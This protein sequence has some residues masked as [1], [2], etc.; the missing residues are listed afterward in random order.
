MPSVSIVLPTRDRPERLR[1]ALE[2]VARQ[3]HPELELIL[4]RDGGAPIAADAEEAIARLEFPAARIEHD[5]PPEGAARARNRGVSRARADAV[6]FLDDDD[7]WTPDHLARLAAFLER[8]PRADVVYADARIVNEETGEA[9]VIARDFDLAVFSRDGYIPPSAMAARR[10]AFDRFGAF[11]PAF[12]FS[13][14]WEWL[15]RVARGGG[16][17]ARSPGATATVRIHAGGLSQVT[18][19]RLEERRRCLALLAER[20]GLGPL[21]PKTFWEVAESVCPGPNATTS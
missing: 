10:G 6:A 1:N 13:E 4:V 2:A 5:G 19:A 16:V 17:I 3:T 11:D 14:D 7:E 21:V 12:G 15:L 18:P 9:H 8:E 20:H